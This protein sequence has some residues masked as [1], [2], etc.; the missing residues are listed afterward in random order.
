MFLRI[1]Y[2]KQAAA[3]KGPPESA[4]TAGTGNL[5]AQ[6]HVERTIAAS[7]ERVFDSMFDQTNLTVSPVIRKSS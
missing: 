3:S 2:T 5:T 4:S 6:I 1:S 7:P